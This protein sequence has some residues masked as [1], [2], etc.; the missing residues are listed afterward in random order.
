MTASA[1]VTSTESRVSHRWRFNAGPDAEVLAGV[2][3]S[4]TT[5]SY[6]HL[7]MP[8]MHARWSSIVRIDDLDVTTSCRR[9]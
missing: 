9:T 5:E 4:T 6:G 2:S 3:A 7:Q 1:N 8:D